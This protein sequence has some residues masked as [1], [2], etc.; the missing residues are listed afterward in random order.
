MNK[1]CLLIQCG[2]GGTKWIKYFIHYNPEFTDKEKDTLVEL[3][4]K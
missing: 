2:D 4:Q 3:L 1:T